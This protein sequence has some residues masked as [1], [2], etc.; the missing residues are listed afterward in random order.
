MMNIFNRHHSFVPIKLYQKKR[1]LPSCLYIYVS[2]IL[3]IEFL[4]RYHRIHST[5]PYYL[6]FYCKGG[7][8][9]SQRINP[10]NVF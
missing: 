7:Y 9:K 2:I 6:K 4:F 10:L 8:P 5:I 1:I 3:T